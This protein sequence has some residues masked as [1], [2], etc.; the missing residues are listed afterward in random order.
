M[1]S[2]SSVMKLEPTQAPLACSLF[3][4]LRW[5]SVSARKRSASATVGFFAGAAST[6]VLAAVMALSANSVLMIFGDTGISLSPY[7]VLLAIEPSG[8]MASNHT[9]LKG[10]GDA[11][12]GLA[13]G[14]QRDVQHLGRFVPD[15]D[16]WPAVDAH[17]RRV[18]RH[19]MHLQ[20]DA[21]LGALVLLAHFGFDAQRQAAALQLAGEV[22]QFVLAL[23]V[24]LRGAAVV[25]IQLARAGAD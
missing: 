23:F 24:G 4:L 12:G 14:R 11:P 25:V 13:A 3:S 7:M 17:Q 19:V 5:S 2:V 21:A 6:V 9:R 22:Q 18:G 15:E 20:S 16:H 10:D 8:S 1:A